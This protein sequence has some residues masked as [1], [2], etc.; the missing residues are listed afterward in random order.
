MLE[1]FSPQPEIPGL[2]LR[3]LAALA[4]T[5]AA[6]YFDAFNKKWVPNYLVYGFLGCAL[7]LNV[8]FFDSALFIQALVIAAA[9][10][11]STYLLYKAG[12]LGGADAYVL[13]S[14]SLCVPYLSKP[15]LAGEQSVPYP[16]I[17]SVLAPTGLAFI[18]HMVARFLPYISRKI[19]KGEVRFGLTKIAGP[20]LL[21]LAFAFFIYSI[22]ILPV[23]LPIQYVAIL[24]FLF[25][26]LFF[27][28]LF[29]EEIKD[30]MVEMVPV[31][32]LQEED[33]LALEKMDKHLAKKLGLSPLI[34]KAAIA[35]LKKS[36]LKRVPVYTGMPFFL[37]YLLLG[38][39]FSLLFGDL[40][41]YLA[42]F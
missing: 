14:I 33:V 25:A 27:F 39:A 34:G 23:A 4:F 36:K 35:I 5:C 9:V 28:S 1:I 20:L 37:P 40:L 8:L 29:K 13:T 31:S 21:L 6:A 16:F 30:S 2:A 38:L 24:S 11:G 18:L 12:Q 17:L 22:S 19:S 3:S 32:R 10:F 41:Y 26:S 7:A 15:F 42:R